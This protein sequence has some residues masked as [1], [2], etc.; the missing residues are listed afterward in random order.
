MGPKDCSDM[1]VW[2]Y[3]MGMC[4][5]LPMADMPM[6]M[7]MVHGNAFLVQN[8]QEGPRGRNAFSSANMLMVD[9]GSSI[10][11]NHYFNVDLMLTAE[12]WT[13][14]KEGY[15]EL[16]QIGEENEDKAPYL[17]AQHPHSSP[18]MG[19]T[20][21]DTISLN[22]NKDHLKLFFAPRGQST[23]G[24]VAFMHRQTGMQNPDAP[25]GHHIGQDVGHI[26]STVVGAS[27]HLNKTTLEGSTFNGTE[28]SPTE[29][30]LPLGSLN[31]Y[32]TRI[33]HE[34][35]PKFY[36]MISA[37]FVKSPEE[38]DPE[39]DHV[40]RYSASIYN[41][42][43][44]SNE[45]MLHN[46]FIWG[47]TNFYDNVSALNSFNEEFWFHKNDANIWGRFEYLQ[48]TPAQLQI[49]S[50]DPLSTH[51]VTA[52]TLGYT[53]NI[54]DFS[55]FNLSLGISATKSFLPSN[56]QAAYDGDPLGGKIFLRIEL[57]KMWNL[58]KSKMEM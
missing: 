5:P 17:D 31:S 47:L 45:W 8:S 54:F 13:F 20:F 43:D 23:E 2:D 28:P 41:T 7:L 48:R 36:A 30:D 37:A 40:W 46:S 26:T 24:P 15:P 12:K 53:H 22:N 29:T 52:L 18:I 49:P 50:P 1:E 19:L 57:M 38:D 14:P 51:W 42:I 10:S 34:F 25:L 44:I 39:L 6:S 58:S 55:S 4:M 21:S 32:S 9:Y 35:T 56:F 16:L 11:S 3:S 27:I 33:I